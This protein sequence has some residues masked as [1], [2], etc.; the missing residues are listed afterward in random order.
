LATKID[1][2]VRLV[3]QILHLSILLT[4][5]EGVK[6]MPLGAWKREVEDEV[7][8]SVVCNQNGD[9]VLTRSNH[10]PDTF[11]PRGSFQTQE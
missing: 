5:L 1:L 8:V 7:F 6:E 2:K 3:I 9:I 10:N 11:P 4:T